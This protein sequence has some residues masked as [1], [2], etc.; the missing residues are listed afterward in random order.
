MSQRR[1]TNRFVR[2]LSK[3]TNNNNIT[4]KILSQNAEISCSHHLMELTRSRIDQQR[5][6]APHKVLFREKLVERFVDGTHPK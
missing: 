5:Q 3:I 6:S 1:I 4:N 2:G